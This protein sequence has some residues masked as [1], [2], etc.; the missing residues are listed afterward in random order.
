MNF[1][2]TLLSLKN[3]GSN[4]MFI[5][6]PLIFHSNQIQCVTDFT[7]KHNNLIIGSRLHILCA[8]HHVQQATQHTF[9]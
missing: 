2:F 6:F 3:V 8:V 5:G 9:K 1:F 7:M 4:L